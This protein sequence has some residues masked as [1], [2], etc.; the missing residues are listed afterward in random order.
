MFGLGGS[1][2]ADGCGNNEV[3]SCIINLIILF[4]VL[5]FL[6]QIIGGVGGLNCG[7]GHRDVCC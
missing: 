5:E 3:W 6:C 1:G 4:I 2:C 7:V